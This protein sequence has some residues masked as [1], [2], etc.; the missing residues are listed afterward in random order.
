MSLSMAQGELIAACKVAQIMLFSMCVLE[1]IGLHVKKPMSL[2]VDCKGALDL[3]YGWHV[4][5]LMKYVSVRAC[6][7]HKLKEANSILC[8][9]IPMAV[10]MVD[11]YTQMCHHI[12][13]IIIIVLLCMMKM[14]TMTSVVSIFI[15][16][17]TLP[18]HTMVTNS[19]GEGV[20]TG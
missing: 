1:D 16:T 9:W 4:S 20:G 17:L 7:L 19:P 13:M 3:I 5:G 10:N 2:Q 18:N 11:M 14:T 6:F 15:R 8:A 12:Y